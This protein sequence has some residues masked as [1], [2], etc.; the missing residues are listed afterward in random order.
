MDGYAIIGSVEHCTQRLAD[1]AALG[2]EKF[3]VAGPNFSSTT[4]D[5]AI[6]AKQMEQVMSQLR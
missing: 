3:S 1:L 5:A 6:A 4:G 2:I